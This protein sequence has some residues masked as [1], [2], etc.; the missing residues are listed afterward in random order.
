MTLLLVPLFRL[1]LLHPGRENLKHNTNNRHHPANQHPPSVPRHG[2]PWQDAE[3]LECPDETKEDQDA[4][5]YEQGDFHVV[6][7]S[8]GE[9]GVKKP[10][11][12]A[13]YSRCRR[14]VLSL[15][16]LEAHRF[17]MYTPRRRSRCQTTRSEEHT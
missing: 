12:I 8:Q 14:T 16:T 7:I 1:F 11:H 4:S 5:H 6:S 3:A 15:V 13:H 9:S 10:T 17:Q 2:T